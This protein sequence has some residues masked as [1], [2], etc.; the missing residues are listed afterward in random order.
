MYENY[1]GDILQKLHDSI[2][3]GVFRSDTVTQMLMIHT[4][5]DYDEISKNSIAVIMRTRS[6]RIKPT[7]QYDSMYRAWYVF[8]DVWQQLNDGSFLLNAGNL[9]CAIEVLLSQLMFKFAGTNETWWA[10]ALALG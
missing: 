2:S 4:L 7:R 1:L 10:C 6:E 9:V 3:A 5:L 8:L